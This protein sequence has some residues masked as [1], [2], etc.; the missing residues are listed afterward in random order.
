[1][2]ALTAIVCIA[3]GLAGL[4]GALWHAFDQG[5]DTAERACQSASLQG[6]LQAQ[7]ERYKSLRTQLSRQ[8][9][10]ATAIHTDKSEVAS[11]LAAAQEHVST[12]PAAKD[13]TLGPAAIEALN[14]VRKAGA[15]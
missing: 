9:A 2:R 5:Y 10:A 15:P 6:E 7:K 1:M 12:I 14:A 8:N 11:L 13:C 4:T 3:L